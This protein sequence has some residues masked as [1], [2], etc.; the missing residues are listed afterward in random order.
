MKPP[1]MT[2]RVLVFLAAI[3]ILGLLRYRPWRDAGAPTATS[4]D[5]KPQEARESLV[6]GYLPVT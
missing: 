1:N 2:P 6:V 3:V 5:G 4:V